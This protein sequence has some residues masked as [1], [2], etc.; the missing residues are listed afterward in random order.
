MNVSLITKLQISSASGKLLKQQLPLGGFGISR[1]CLDDSLATIARSHGVTILENC[2]VKDINFR[3]SFFSIEAAGKTYE[4]KVACASFG[5]RS[6]L[7]VKWKRAFAESAANKLNNYIGIKYHIKTDF[8]QDTIALHNFKNGYCGIV[9]IEDD[10]Y[11]LC[12]LTTADNLRKSGGNIQSMEEKILSVNPHLRKVFQSCERLHAEPLT[13]SQISFDKKAQV[14]DHIIMI[15]DAAGMIT[16]LCGNGMSMAMHGS[17]LAAKQ[18]DLFLKG[19]ISRKQMESNYIQDWQQ[20]FSSRLKIGRRIQ[21]LFGNNAA[22][23][24][25]ISVLKQMPFVTRHLIRRT[26]GRRF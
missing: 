22:T 17:K 25:L 6:N 7:D 2:K 12:Y 24:I 13:I 16:P 3:Q 18:V 10:L 23:G 15:G 1:Y 9:K 21:K 26:H 8:P 20:Q 11:N 4:A 19:T 5:K 14:E